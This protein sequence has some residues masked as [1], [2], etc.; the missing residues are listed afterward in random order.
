MRPR[1]KRLLGDLEETD[2]GPIWEQDL[3]G[4][5]MKYL[6]PVHGYAG[7][8]IPLM[9]GWDWLTDSQRART[10][11]AVPRTLSEECLANRFRHVVARRPSRRQAPELCQYCHGAPAWSRH[12]PMRPSR[13]PSSR[14]FCSKGA[15]TPWRQARSPRA[16]TFVTAPSGNGYAFLKLY[17]RTTE[18]SGS[19]ARGHSR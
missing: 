3:Y 18:R 6:G 5:H 2:E 7:N 8:M 16:P 17:R 11:D 19:S 1:L 15:N 10:V 9:R 4:R 13:L 14:R 12:L